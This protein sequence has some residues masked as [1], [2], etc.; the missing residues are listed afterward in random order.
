MWTVYHAA[1]EFYALQVLYSCLDPSDHSPPW[2]N[3]VLS[4]VGSIAYK[5]IGEDA[6]QL[7]RLVWPLSI[8]LLRTRDLIHR[9]W[10]KDQLRKANTLLPNFG[11]PGPALDGQGLLGRL[12]LESH[13]R[14]LLESGSPTRRLLEIGLRPA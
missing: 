5:A 6:R 3:T 7:Y 4:Q 11:L 13:Q 1:L 10:L 8:T 9:D 14:N 2:L 12:I